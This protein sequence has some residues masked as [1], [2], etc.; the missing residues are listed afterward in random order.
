MSQTTA[1]VVPYEKQLDADPRWAL[2]EGSRHFEEK[3]AVFQ[4]LHKIARRLD[5]LGVPYAVVGAMAMFRHGLRRCTEDVDLLVTRDNLARIHDSKF[6]RDAE[7]GVRIEF[8][9]TGD[10]PGDG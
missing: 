6:L 2:S 3:S 8:L 9:S 1:A 5:E 10:Y 7:H 4:T